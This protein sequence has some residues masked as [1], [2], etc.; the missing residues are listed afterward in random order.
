[1]PLGDSE[2][3]FATLKEHIEALLVE[4]RRANEQRFEGQEKAVNAALTAAK[5]AVTKAEIAAEKRFDAA[6]EFRGQLSDQAAT[7]MPR[8]E[9]E[10]RIGVNADKVTAIENRIN[11]MSGR[12]NGLNASWGYLTAAVTA[13]VGIA[14]I[15]IAIANGVHP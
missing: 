4:E 10:Q 12:S 2:W 7:F 14:L 9:A 5:E 13:L 3:T 6:N 11:L 1:V 8:L 15:V